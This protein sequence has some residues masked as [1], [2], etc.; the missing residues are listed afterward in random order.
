MYVPI[1]LLF[2]L[3]GA[4]L[5]S[6]YKTHPEMLSEV[7]QQVAAERAVDP[8]TLG[9]ADIGDKVLP[10]FIATQLPPGVAGLLIAAIFAAAMSS[11]DTSLNSSATVILKDFYQRYI[12]RGDPDERSSMRVLRLATVGM[13]VVGTIIALSLIGQNSIL[14]A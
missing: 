10:H 11:I 6:Y 13:G 14:D 9:A 7:T 8:A 4:C 12:Q 1:S 2:F 5:H 3:I